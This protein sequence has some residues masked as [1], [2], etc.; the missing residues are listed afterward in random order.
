MDIEMPHV[1]GIE[2]LQSIKKEIPEA[3]VML[4]TAVDED[5]KVFSALCF[6]ASGYAL[7]ADTQMLEKAV[8]DAE[9]GNAY[10]SP[11]IAIKVARL[12]KSKIATAQKGYV[13]LSK[14]QLE[15]L[16][17]LAEGK[18]NEAIAEE[19]HIGFDAVRFHIKGIFEKLQVNS[20][21]LAVKEAILRGII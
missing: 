17:G 7:K 6:G 16:N 11:T 14:R 2:A 19:L 21:L 8:L 9:E 18:T 13:E 1:S 12:F 5:D 3:K 20:A 15:M 10:F 4:L